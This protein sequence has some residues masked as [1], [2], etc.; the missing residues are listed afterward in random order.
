[1][2]PHK[3]TVLIE[4][5][6]EA[7]PHSGSEALHEHEVEGEMNECVSENALKTLHFVYEDTE[8]ENKCS[9]ADFETF[10]TDVTDASDQDS[11]TLMARSFGAF[12]IRL[13][14]YTLAHVVDEQSAVEGDFDNALT[15]IDVA[16]H[17]IA[18]H[19][20]LRQ[21][22]AVSFVLSLALLR[23]AKARP[24]VAPRAVSH[25][26]R[27]AL[28]SLLEKETAPIFDLTLKGLELLHSTQSD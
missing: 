12:R 14:N 9:D 15:R 5:C 28:L 3:S 8:D 13:E 6:Q 1:M 4:L 18:S 27:A 21:Q 26:R 25:F 11:L 24:E 10:V 17:L 7:A 16:Q 23:A 2:P 20:Q 22:S 19:L